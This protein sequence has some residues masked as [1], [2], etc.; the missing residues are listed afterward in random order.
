MFIPYLKIEWIKSSIFILIIMQV[1]SIVTSFVFA[2][3]RIISIKGK[4]EK[5]YLISNYLFN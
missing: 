2:L 4:S 1:L 5:I 3:L